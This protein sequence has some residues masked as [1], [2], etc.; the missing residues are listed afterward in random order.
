MF[1]NSNKINKQKLLDKKKFREAQ[2]SSLG[3]MQNFHKALEITKSL[4][5]IIIEAGVGS[6]VSLATL[7]KLNSI[8]SPKKKIEVF[9]SFKSFPQEYTDAKVTRPSEG[10][11]L[12]QHTIDNLKICDI[13]TTDIIFHEGFFSDTFKKFNPK[14]ISLIHLDVDLGKSYEECLKFFWKHLE[15]KGVI[16]FDEYD[17]EIDLIKWP[18]A[19]PLIDKFFKNKKIKDINFVGQNRRIIQKI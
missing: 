4:K 10:V 14:S 11:S 16:I 18:D 17:H 13:N 9:D 15:K 1:F 2:F 6:G 3:R 19:K 8:I 12:K 5:G 7:Y